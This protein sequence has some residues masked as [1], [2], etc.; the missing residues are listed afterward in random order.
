MINFDALDILDVLAI[1][2]MRLS[3]LASKLGISPRH[4]VVPRLV[5]HYAWN[6]YTAMR[7]RL[8][9]NIKKAQQYEAICENIYRQIPPKYR[10]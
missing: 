9:G 8:E 2:N 5:H 1:A 3:D 6:K 10:W 4:K 7:L